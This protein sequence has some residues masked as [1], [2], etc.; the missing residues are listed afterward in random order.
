MTQITSAILNAVND[1]TAARAYGDGWLVTT[2]LTYSD[3]DAITILV[4]PVNHGFRVTDRAEALDR[5]T[6]WGVAHDSQRANAGVIAARNAAK[7]SPLG[8]H[9]TETATFVEES[10]VGH[11]VLSVAQAA[12]RTEQLRWLAQDRPTS[13]FDERLANRVLTLAQSHDWQMRRRAEMTLRGG[14]TRRVTASVQGPRGTAYIQAVSDTDPDRSV[15]RCFYLFGRSVEN[16]ANKVSALAGDP[17][18]WS[19]D[20]CD[21]LAEVSVLTFFEEATSLERELERITGD[22]VLPALA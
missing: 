19:R 12:L 10:E 8:S 7:L 13:N 5:L 15:Q 9:P 22:P 11:A 21:D 14:R 4:E 3:G 2:P 17:S 6:A 16:K 18:S 20:F 1:L